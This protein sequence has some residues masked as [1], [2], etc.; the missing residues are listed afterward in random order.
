MVAEIQNFEHAARLSMASFPDDET[1]PM[2]QPFWAR[3][4]ARLSALAVV[5][6]GTG[7]LGVSF[8]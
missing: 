1:A 7:L 4:Y 2:I 8:F 3:S 5:V 6:I